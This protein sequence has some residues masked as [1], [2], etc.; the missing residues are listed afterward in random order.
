MLFQIILKERINLMTR[1]E[2]KNNRPEGYSGKGDD[3]LLLLID[4]LQ[5]YI[6][7]IES[8]YNN[9]S[10]KFDKN[11]LRIFSS[12]IVEFAEDLHNDTGLWRS[13]ESY[14]E[15]LFSTPLPLF[16]EDK[17]EIT[18]L[19]DKKRLK[20]FIHTILL[21]FDPDL[22]LSPADS[23]VEMLAGKLSAYLS[24]SFKIIPKDS[25]IKKFLSQ[26]NE[27]YWQFKQK[28]VWAGCNSY[29]FRYSRVRYV[30]EKNNGKIDIPVI[31]DF[32]CQENSI[33]SGLGVIDIMAKALDLPESIQNDVR[34]WYERFFA[35]YRVCAT[36]KK[37]MEVEN[38]INGCRYEIDMDANINPFK[39]DHIVFGSIVRYQNYWYW[40]GAQQDC[41][42]IKDRDRLNDIKN[43]FIRKSSRIIYRYDEQRLNKAKDAMKIQYDDFV[44]FFGEELVSFNDG[45][46]MAAALQKKD[47]QKYETLP[48]DELQRLMK[49]RG[50]KNPFPAMS[51]PDTLLKA[52]NG[53]AVFFNKNEG[54]EIM[55]NYNSL[56][57]GLKKQG[58]KLTADEV[59]TIRGFIRSK[60]IS[61]DFVYY[62]LK[63]Y[64][65]RSI[66]KAYVLDINSNYLAYLLRK[67]KGNYYRKRYPEIT[68][69]DE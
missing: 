21:E 52:E 30:E 6:R 69:L 39:K 16:V 46:S 51:L 2:F 65:V 23:D 18:E 55:L 59:E 41:G 9:N 53:I 68:V 64:G 3:H 43:D 24:S 58:E 8:Y 29:L 63:E 31:D 50:L 44:K 5:K 47:R 22:F 27:R 11:Q 19:F 67:H 26:P 48:E 38:I 33:W 42:I 4:N 13:I 32:I 40:S 28:L 45:L 7:G 10:L 35:F 60:A 54:M 20:Y 61:P 36:G 25:G 12:L 56:I 37:I 57:N 49:K 15:Q 62:L 66:Q 17:N 34:S 1:Q 14:N